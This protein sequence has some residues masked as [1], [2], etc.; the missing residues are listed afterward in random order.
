M[1]KSFQVIY[2]GRIQINLCL[3]PFFL[4]ACREVGVYELDTWSASI[5]TVFMV[6]R[7]EQKL[8]RSSRL[9]PSRSITRTL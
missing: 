7:R 5:R 9:G 3:V 1:D 8:N 6:K 4:K 2:E